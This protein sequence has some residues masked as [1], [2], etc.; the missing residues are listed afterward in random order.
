AAA[1]TDKAKAV[2]HL[3]KAL[4]AYAKGLAEL[5]DKAPHVEGK[6]DT[7][8]YERYYK[9]N[10]ETINLL[11]Q[12]KALPEFWKKVGFESL[13]SFRARVKEVTEAAVKN[14]GT[15]RFVHGDTNPGN[16]F[17]SEEG[18]TTWIDCSTVPLGVNELG[19]GIA[20]AGRDITSL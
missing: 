16:E 9:F 3:E 2:A 14:P 8:A 1:G 13:A 19:L 7:R 10:E 12:S 11:T 15:A 17:Y 20:P 18:K 4:D 6:A 5:H